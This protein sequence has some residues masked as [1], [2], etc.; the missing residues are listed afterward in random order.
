V[1]ARRALTVLEL[2]FDSFDD[3]T[4]EPGRSASFHTRIT[5]KLGWANGKS[6]TYSWAKQLPDV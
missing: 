6:S 2:Q 4:L 3:V 5:G 1:K